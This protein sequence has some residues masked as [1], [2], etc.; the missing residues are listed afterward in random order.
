MLYARAASNAAPIAIATG[1]TAVERLPVS[2]SRVIITAKITST[3][4]PPP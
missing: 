4:M 1:C 3:A 2:T